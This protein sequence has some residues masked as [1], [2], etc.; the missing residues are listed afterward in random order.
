MTDVDMGNS[1]MIQNEGM[2]LQEEHQGAVQTPLETR[3][4]SFP[5]SPTSCDM[6]M[7]CIPLDRYTP[8]LIKANC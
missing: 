6:L 3:F 2:G 7:L 1:S 8:P 4:L 5:I